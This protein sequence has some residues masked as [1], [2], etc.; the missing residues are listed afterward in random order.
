M[1]WE[2]KIVKWLL[3]ERFYVFFICFC[4]WL[5]CRY[6]IF[7]NKLNYIYIA[8]SLQ[9]YYFIVVTDVGSRIKESQIIKS[10]VA[11]CS[12]KFVNSSILWWEI[13][14]VKIFKKLKFNFKTRYK[15]CSTCRF[16]ITQ[17]EFSI[18]LKFKH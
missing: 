5:F 17:C 6:F 2:H 3:I 9:F 18:S 13:C 15:T 12:P 14:K 1:L 8:D 16:S 4:C 11:N 10:Y 7:I